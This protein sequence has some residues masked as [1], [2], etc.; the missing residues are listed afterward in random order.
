VRVEEHKWGI[1]LEDDDLAADVT[2]KEIKINVTGRTVKLADAVLLIE[3]L[4]TLVDAA[5]AQQRN[6]R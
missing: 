4:R 6:L 5:R 2:S 3:R 1:H